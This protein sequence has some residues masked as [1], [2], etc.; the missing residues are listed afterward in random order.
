MNPHHTDITLILD[1]SG[2]MNKIRQATI[3]G[4]NDFIAEQRQLP[5]TVTISLVQ[6][7]N[8]RK[9]S[10]TA[11]PIHDVP[12][13]DSEEYKPGGGTALLDAIS[14]TIDETGRRLASLAERELPSAVIVAILTD[15][16]EN[17]SRRFT[18]PQV[19]GRIKH[20]QSVYNWNFL[21]LAAD[22]DAI[23]EAAR[24]SILAGAAL[25]FRKSSAGS[26]AAFKSLSK[27]AG[28]LRSGKK[29]RAAFDEADRQAQAKQPPL[30]P[31][32]G[33]TDNKQ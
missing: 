29:N 18:H 25:T 22:Q 21:F 17:S 10:Y 27:A 11:A 23:A 20:Q 16:K 13:L 30:F 33:P 3:D 26:G 2:S 6:F 15:G 1:R 28:D 12:R 14:E 8:R 9:V 24:L 7:S 19:V 5:G 4:F 31:P 32:D